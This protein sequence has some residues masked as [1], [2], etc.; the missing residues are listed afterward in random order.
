M[1]TRSS[2]NSRRGIV[3]DDFFRLR[4]GNLRVL[5]RL[6]CSISSDMA[7]LA[8]VDAKRIRASSVK[9]RQSASFSNLFL[10]GGAA[11][12]R[13]LTA[14]RMERMARARMVIVIDGRSSWIIRERD[15]VL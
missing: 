14:G 12:L 7:Y 10:P 15:A 13:R 8:R 9:P 11:G 6:R 3:R 2:L 4:T 1:E 5:V